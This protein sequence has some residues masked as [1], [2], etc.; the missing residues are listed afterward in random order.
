[1]TGYKGGDGE[2]Q[3]VQALE[4]LL[5]AEETD[6]VASIKNRYW[7]IGSIIEIA[8]AHGYMSAMGR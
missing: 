2:P 1:M 3:L 5:T 6:A 4:A 8:Q 7:V